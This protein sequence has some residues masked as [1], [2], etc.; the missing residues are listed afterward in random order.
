VAFAT[1][2][3]EGSV[4]CPRKVPGAAGGVGGCAVI[5]AATGVT[6]PPTVATIRI[7]TIKFVRI[8]KDIFNTHP[9]LSR[10]IECIRN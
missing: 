10:Q 5:C 4:T 9:V 7:A 2:A 3:P 1:T 8:N 6:N